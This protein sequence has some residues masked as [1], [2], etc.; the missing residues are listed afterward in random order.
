[1][2]LC[3]TSDDAQHRQNPFMTLDTR[4]YAVAVKGDV[5]IAQ[6]VADDVAAG[7]PSHLLIA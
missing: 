5:K 7:G 1:M 2:L 3:E 4:D 6:A